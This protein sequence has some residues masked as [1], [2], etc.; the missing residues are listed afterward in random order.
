MVG[1][2]RNGRVAHDLWFQLKCLVERVRAKHDGRFQR[3]NQG[4]DV[5]LRSSWDVWRQLSVWPCVG[6]ARL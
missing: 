5:R 6:G 1:Q 4:S 3:R 2:E